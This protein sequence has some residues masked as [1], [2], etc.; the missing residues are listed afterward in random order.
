[1][2]NHYHMTTTTAQAA[3]VLTHLEYYLQLVWPELNVNVVSSTE[4]WAGAAIAGPKSRNVLQ[5]LFPDLDVSNKGL[6]FMGYVEG[7][8]FGVNARIFRISFSGELAYEVNVES[9][10]GNFMWNKIM[11]IGKEFNIQPYGTEALSTLRIEM[12][13]VAGS[14]IDGRVIA[15]DLS[16][17]G[18]LSKKKDFIGKRSLNREAFLKENREKIV[19]VVPLDKKTMIPEG[20]HL[21]IDKNSSL[22]NPKLG[23]VSA[24]CWSVEYN[25]PFSLAILKD[26]KKKIGQTLYALAPLKNQSIPVK[27]VSSHYVDP[28]GE[29]VRS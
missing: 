20:S 22:P 25:N 15:S 21:V 6:P 18:M 28:K 10:N 12:G 26:G 4:Q 9:D 2:E 8:L 7:N 29:R 1:M 11:E 5:K 16:L 13:H 27:I 14:E 23:H 19:G 24:S 3:N 17:E